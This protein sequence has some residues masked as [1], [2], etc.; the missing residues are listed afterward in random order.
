VPRVTAAD[1]RGN[2]PIQSG[3]EIALGAH[4]DDLL[5]NVTVLKN[6]QCGDGFDAVFDSQAL[7]LVDVDFANANFAVVFGGEFIKDWSNHFTRSAPF[8]PKV[9][10]S[11]SLR[12]DDFGFKIGVS[13]SENIASHIIIPLQRR[14]LTHQLLKAILPAP[15]RDKVLHREHRE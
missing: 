2:D 10:E 14:V 12:L 8:R 4:S 5:R 11:R 1:L 15:A 6:K 13:E 3:F 7:V 9:D